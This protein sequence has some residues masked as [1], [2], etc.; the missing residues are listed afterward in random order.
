MIRPQAGDIVIVDWRVDARPKEPTKTRPAVV[1]EDS[2]LFPDGYPNLL[3][4]PMTTD[5]GLAHRAFA[6]RIDPDESDGVT[7]RCWVLAHHVTS[8]SLQRVRA[9]GSHVTASELADIRTRLV[10]AVGGA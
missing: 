3:V 1:V 4:T 8:V 6:V 5:E 9:T 2:G 7:S 10:L